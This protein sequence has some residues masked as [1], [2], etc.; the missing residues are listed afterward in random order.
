MP[1]KNANSRMR[2]VYSLLIILALSSLV[3]SQRAVKLK[4]IELGGDFSLTDHNG[5]LF[6]LS[7]QRG[8]IVLL[9]FGYTSCTEACPAMLAKVASAYKSLGPMSSRVQALLVNVDPQRDTHESL[10]QYLSYF[11][12]G[13]IGLTGSREQID[14]VVK[15][16]GAKYEIEKST[17]ALG[18]Q[19]NHTTDLYLIDQK[20]KVR[21]IFK[22]DDHP[23]L[24]VSGIKQLIKQET[25]GAAVR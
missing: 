17:S 22:H 14:A 18:Y 1:E 8:K 23:A 13:A 6:N 12:V 20:G 15:Q 7:S 21:Y 25:T 2:F 16:Y 4:E 11:K 3:A 19:V 24:I 10:R 5:S 9:Y